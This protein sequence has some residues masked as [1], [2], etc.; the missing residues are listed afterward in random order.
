[1]SQAKL[2]PRNFKDVAVGEEIPKLVKQPSNLSV[3]LFGVAYWTAHR[4]HYDTKWAQSE[5]YDDVL[6]TG[7]LMNAY[8]VRA[9]TNWAGDPGCFRKL[10]VRN[11]ATAVGGD[12][13]EVT[14]RVRDKRIENGVGVVE[15]D[16]A[17]HKQDGTRVVGGD[18]V[19]HLRV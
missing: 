9:L 16:V 10:K 14:A 8:A 19:L 2:S 13:L 18:A 12:T 6:V 7:P 11:L 4:I 1:M 15:C 3:F 17:I 5:G